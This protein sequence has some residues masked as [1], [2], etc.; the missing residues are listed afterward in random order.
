MYNTSLETYDTGGIHAYQDDRQFNCNTIIR[1]N[2]VHDGV[3][4]SSIL[5]KP[6]FDSRGIYIDG[7]SSGYTITHNICY[8]NSASGGIFIV[9]PLGPADWNFHHNTI[10]G[11]QKPVTLDS[12]GSP[13]SWFRDNVM[14]RGE[15][16]GVKAAIEVRGMFKLAGN[17]ISGFDVLDKMVCGK[18]FPFIEYFLRNI[19]DEVLPMAV[20]GDIQYG[21]NRLSNGWLVYLINNK[22]VIKF[23]NRAQTFD[24]SK[25]A[26]VEVS[27]KDIRA[28]AITELR[29]QKTIAKDEKSNTFSVD[30]P[31]AGGGVMARCPR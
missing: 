12:Y 22:G 9:F 21:L 19:V 4:Y 18:K 30:V 24:M 14:T 11:C 17:Q 3:G 7:F 29:E 26:R 10:T 8:R 2:L 15:A 16:S 31:P 5:G 23:T 20:K 27:L 6:L 25:T 28:A 1:Y 13:T